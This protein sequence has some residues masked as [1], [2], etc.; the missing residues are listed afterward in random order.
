MITT[1]CLRPTTIARLKAQAWIADFI[2]I[3][4]RCSAKHFQFKTMARYQA[5]NLVLYQSDDARLILAAWTN[6]PY[7]QLLLAE[8]AGGIFV[9]SPTVWEREAA[10]RDVAGEILEPKEA[11]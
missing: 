9:E 1:N 4:N 5:G 8:L 2:A 10:F 7:P 3:A 6:G 11:V